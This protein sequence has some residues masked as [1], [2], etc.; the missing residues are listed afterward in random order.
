M[1]LDDPRTLRSDEQAPPDTSAYPKK[2]RVIDPGPLSEARITDRAFNR[3]FLDRSDPLEDKGATLPGF[4]F[5]ASYPVQRDKQSNLIHKLHANAYAHVRGGEIPADVNVVDF[6]DDRTRSR[7]EPRRYLVIEAETIRSTRVSVYTTFLTY[8]DNLYVALDTF[9]LPPLSVLRALVAGIVTVLVLAV[10]SLGGG[11]LGFLL[12]GA[13]VAWFFR[14]VVRSL[15][16]GDR[17]EL[18]LR[19][20][21]P[22]SPKYSTFDTD[23][24][25]VFFKSSVPLVLRSIQEVFEDADIP[26]DVLERAIQNVNFVNTINTGGGMFNAVNSVL[27]G[28]GNRVGSAAAPS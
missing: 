7:E 21:F 1:S 27:A 2:R 25:L 13:L 5:A 16:Q 9:I 24:V 6:H 20:K 11:I 17:P 15:S 4:N 14:D 19:K 8:G 22:K 28:V 12:W 26:V 10:A 18:A 3:G 23:D